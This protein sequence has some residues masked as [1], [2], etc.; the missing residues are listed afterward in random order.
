MKRKY[1]LLALLACV[2]LNS[3]AQKPGVFKGQEPIKGVSTTDKHI[4]KQWK[5]IFDTPSANVF[6]RNDFTGARLNGVKQIADTSFEV[7]IKPE[8][9]PIN[10]S[11]WYA[12]KVWSVKP[13]KIKIKFTYPNNYRH[14][15]E[16]KISKD[17]LK[18]ALLNQEEKKSDSISNSRPKDEVFLSVGPDTL[19]VAAQELLTSKDAIKWAE[20][21]SRFGKTI[22]ERIGTTHGGKPFEIFSLGNPQ[23]KKHILI[24]G[25]Q[26]PPEVTGQLA[27]QAFAD[28]LVSSGQLS[29][30]FLKDYQIHIIPIMNPDGVDEGF[31]RHSFGGIDLNR[32][33]ANFN[34]PETAAVR[35]FLKR[36]IT[37]KGDNLV[38]GIDFHSTHDDIYYIVDPKLKSKTPGLIDSWLKNTVK[39]IPDYLPNIK[40]LYEAPPTYTSFSYLYETFG[41]EALVYEIGD[42][43]DRDFIN[44]KAKI[45]AVELLKLL[46]RK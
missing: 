20:Q 32:D 1:S 5:G 34:Q 8:N 44:K 31:W 45:S 26:H 11:P 40:P 33:W 28:A 3:Y 18:W 21:L 9:E 38:F 16:P 14:R 15:Y 25:R 42:R 24:L 27:M 10:G 7:L 4:E 29:K 23:S 35:D 2:T 39:N 46:T 43:T 12:F 13:V 41:A 37:D 19:W 17:G 6:F 22:R 36:K 30:Q